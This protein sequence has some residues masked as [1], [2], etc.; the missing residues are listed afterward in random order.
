[1]DK[2]K[3]IGLIVLFFFYHTSFSQSIVTDRPD[4]TESSVTVPAGSLQIESG[5]I[6]GYTEDFNQVSRQ[7]A[8]ASLFR[9]GVFKSLEFRAFTQYENI[10][11]DDGEL[12]GMSDTEVGVKIQILDT[13]NIDTKIAF[14]S[15]VVTPTG[16][17]GLSADR[18]GT[19]NKLAVSHN[20]LDIFGLGYNL[21]HSYFGESKGD[22][23]YSVV[24]G[25][26]VNDRASFYIEPY[27]E[28]TNMEDFITN[29]NG[30]VTYLITDNLQADIAF[31]TGIDNRM[32]YV[33]F[34]ISWRHLKKK[35]N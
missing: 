18:Y 19:V 35:E 22:F 3:I 26:S 33:G 4:Q 5:M 11:S 8:P 1:M 15:H 27:G 16:S 9:I 13:E 30:G 24:F 29:I 14:I 7:L 12:E 32:N 2:I 31:G 34:G 25:F 17:L 20:I 6:L 10:S 21:G 28:V 23:L